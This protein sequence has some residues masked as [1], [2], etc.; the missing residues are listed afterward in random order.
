MIPHL[1]G[2]SNLVK[3]LQWRGAHQGDKTAFIFLKDGETEEVSMSYRELDRRARVIATLLQN[4]KANGERVLLLYPPG[5][6]YISA[7]FGCLYVGAI[8]VPVYPP[9]PARINRTLPRLQAIA[10]DARA[11]FILTTQ[12]ILAMAETF[13]NQ[14]S[15]LNALSWLA[16]DGLDDAEDHWMEPQINGDTLA[17]LQYTSGSTGTPKGV[18]LCHENLM[19]TVEMMGSSF[20]VKEESVGVSWLPAYHD[21]GLIGLILLPVHEGKPCILLSPLSFLRRPIR[22]LQAITRYKANVSGAPNFA[23]ELCVNRISPEQR[24]TLDLSSWE[25]AFSASEPV[26][27]QT[28]KKFSDYFEPCGFRPETFSAC[29]GLAEATLVVSGDLNRS[30]PTI[31]SFDK[32]LLGLHKASEVKEKDEDAQEIVGCGRILGG[33]K[34]II[35]DPETKQRLPSNQVGEIWVQGK[36]VARGYW[37]HPE[38]TQETFMAQLKDTQEGPFLR[39]GDLGFLNDQGLFVTGRLKDLI[40]IL[41]QNHYP[42]DIEMLVENSHPAVVKGCGGAFSIEVN[43]IEHLAIAQEVDVSQAASLKEV[44]DAIRQAV[45]N[46][47]GVEVYAVALIRPKTIPKTSSGKIQRHA[48]RSSFISGDLEILYSSV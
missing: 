39:T 46:Y 31:K 13:S 19:V 5:L 28:L 9:D 16:T 27:A 29:Y 44:A 48:C 2:S 23:Y 21:M 11:K 15:D 6:E 22:W 7:F 20:P 35:V 43:G 26:R 34:V 36:N 37:D 42:Q 18:M 47:C 14:I 32:K 40:I 4:L 30:L 10:K 24:M 3:I 8:A 45:I 38:E 12:P 33:Q 25:L 17:F 41:G 1:R